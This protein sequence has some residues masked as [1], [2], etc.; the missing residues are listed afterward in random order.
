[1]TKYQNDLLYKLAETVLLLADEATRDEEFNNKLAELN[2]PMS[3]D[4]WGHEILC[5]AW[6]E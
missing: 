4:A 6:K 5:I 3:L 2:P 1:M